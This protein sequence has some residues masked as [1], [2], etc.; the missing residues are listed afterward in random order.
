MEPNLK[1]TAAIYSPTTGIVDIQGSVAKFSA[2]C[3]ACKQQPFQ[4][5]DLKQ[6]DAVILGR[7]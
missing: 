3:S 4:D 6:V 1:C 2:T 7:C 5:T